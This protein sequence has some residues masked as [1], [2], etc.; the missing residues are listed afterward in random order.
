VLLEKSPAPEAVI[1]LSAP[2]NA[3]KWVVVYPGVDKSPAT[4]NQNELEDR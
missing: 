3:L 1:R 2:M 4:F